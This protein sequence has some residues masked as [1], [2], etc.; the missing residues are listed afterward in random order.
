MTE[1][2]RRLTH[3]NEPWVWTNEHDQAF[4]KLKRALITAPVTAYFDS[5]KETEILVWQLFSLKLTT[6]VSGAW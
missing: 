6:R 3:K 1:P 2:L 5:E 4:D